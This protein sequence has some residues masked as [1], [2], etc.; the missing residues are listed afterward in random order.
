MTLLDRYLTRAILVPTAAAFL[1][2]SFIIV[3]NEMK[4]Q[5]SRLIVQFLTAKDVL[6]LGGALLPSLLPMILPA[7]VFFGV[8]MGYGRLAERGE[9]TAIR[10]A[11]VSLARIVTPAIAVGLVATLGTMVLQD[12]LLPR[13]MTYARKMLRE[14]LPKRATLDTISPGVMH[15]FGDWRVYFKDRNPAAHELREVVVV[16]QEPGQGAVV[17]HAESATAS[18][19]DSGAT[20]LLGPGYW[21]SPDGIRASCESVL[22]HL[23]SPI[24]ASGNAISLASSSLVQLSEEELS[25]SAELLRSK[26]LSIEKKLR[27]ARSMIA[28]RLSLPF[29]AVLF[30]CVGAPMAAE[31]ARSRRGGRQRLLA[32]GLIPVFGYYF[33]HTALQSDS[34]KPLGETLLRAWIPNFLLATIAAALFVRATRVH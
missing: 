10:S 19:D 34:L 25:L 27:R 32:A 5:M 12:T 24:P 14:E 1:V 13:T 22:L 23:P 9:I 18:M 15:P 3:A 30:A 16:R 33:L 21:V 31:S 2:V 28:E 8:L 26:S 20:L 7:A 11:G 6:I 4:E 17:Y 29:A